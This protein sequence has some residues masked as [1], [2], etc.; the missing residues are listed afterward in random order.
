MSG[1]K[2]CYSL[3]NEEFNYDE[4]DEAI[5][6][7]IDDPKINIGDVV[8]VYE[9]DAVPFKCGDFVGS[10]LDDITN[11]AYDEGGEYSEDYLADVTKEEEADLNKRVAD[12]VNQ[13]ADDYGYQPKFYRVDNA[14]ELQAKF[15]GGDDGYEI[16]GE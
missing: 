3:N 11:T 16:L 7:A 8:T 6:D 2:K 10:I 5:R 1:K 14:K 15:I 12:V 9:G 4:L 13:W